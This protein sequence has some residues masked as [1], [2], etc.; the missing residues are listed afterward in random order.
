M[1]KLVDVNKS[2][3]KTP[4]LSQINLKLEDNK[5]YGLLGRNGVGKTTLLNMIG[6]QIKASSGHI[7]LDDQG[8]FE[9]SQALSD[10][11][12]VKEEG[13]GVEDIKLKEI[14]ETA[15]ILYKNWDEDYKD[16]L[17]NEF[18]L[19]SKKKFNKLSRGNQTLVGLIVGLASRARYTIFDE[20]SLGLD[21]AHRD[22]FYSL[23][24]EDWEKNP[25]TIV[26]STHL[27]DEVTSVFEEVII[28]KDE[29]VFIKEEVASLMKRAY[30]LNGNQD[31]II[32]VIDRDKIIHREKFG[33]TVIIA[34]F[35][36]L[37]NGTKED[38]RGKN[39]EISPIPL[40][41]LFIYLTENHLSKE[42][43]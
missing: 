14:F 35:D 13:I 18:N 11:C 38:L 28:L 4:V 31:T 9:N 29:K 10:I 2:Y 20:P 23:I 7:S 21:A 6:N 12:I 17:I 24:L 43:M 30:Y 25:R 3:G 41:K 19:D 27:I 16:L 33:N 34:L 40:Q 1:I 8:I 36:E 32:S 37:D 39:I 26:I 42:A 15:G 22:R 5:I